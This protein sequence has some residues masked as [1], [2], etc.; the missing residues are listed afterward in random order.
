MARTF[1]AG[2]TAQAPRRN[3]PAH[4]K[5]APKRP[6][7]RSGTRIGRSS[8]QVSEAGAVAKIA[9]SASAG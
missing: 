8:S 1:R 5:S 3:S 7:S 4:R 6:S 2:D 9:R